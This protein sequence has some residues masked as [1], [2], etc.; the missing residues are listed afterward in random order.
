MKNKKNDMF[1]HYIRDYDSQP[2]ITVCVKQLDDNNIGVGFSV[3]VMEDKCVK[4]MGQKYAHKYANIAL[5]Q[6]KKKNF[7]QH[8]IDAGTAP[9]LIDAIGYIPPENFLLTGLTKGSINV[10]AQKNVP[11][12]VKYIFEKYCNY[13]PRSRIFSMFPQSVLINNKELEEFKQWVQK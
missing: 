5:G 8:I 2:R 7:P 3:C 1:Y 4:K 6:A 9:N 11:S 10:Y 13:I 12:V